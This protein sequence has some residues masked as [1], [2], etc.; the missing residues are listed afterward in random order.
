[1]VESFPYKDPNEV[2]DYILDWTSRIEGDTIQ[3]SSWSIVTGSG[4]VINSDNVDNT[5]KKTVVWLSAGTEGIT[6]LLL[7][8]ITTAGGRTMDQ[9]VKLKVKSK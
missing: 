6:Y 8:R 2:L 4:L 5:F 9:S 3:T 1:M 7:N